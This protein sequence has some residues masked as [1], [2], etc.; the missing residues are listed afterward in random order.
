MIYC[1]I[2]VTMEISISA[3]FSCF[4]STRL[5]RADIQNCRKTFFGTHCLRK[6]GIISALIHIQN[7]FYAHFKANKTPFPMIYYTNIFSTVMF[8]RSP[9]LIFDLGFVKMRYFNFFGKNTLCA[10]NNYLKYM[11]ISS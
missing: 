6:S 3:K 8:S 10:C 9:N 7:S 5:L 2:V 1:E 11:K 4:M